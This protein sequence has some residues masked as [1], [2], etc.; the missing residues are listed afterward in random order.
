VD[1]NM[2]V[3]KQAKRRG[4]SCAELARRVGMS[5]EVLRRSL[6]GTRRFRAE[7]LLNICFELEMSLLD[8][9]KN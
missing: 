3:A 5:P 7:E 9:N 8:L 4:I 6:K 2:N 1:I